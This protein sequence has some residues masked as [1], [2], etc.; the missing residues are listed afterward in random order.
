MNK[1]RDHEITELRQQDMNDMK[2][3]T[4]LRKQI[5]K[6]LSTEMRNQTDPERKV[7]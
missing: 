2:A 4:E 7:L 5:I 6:Q 1:S 3:I